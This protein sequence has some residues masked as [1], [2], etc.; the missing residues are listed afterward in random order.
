MNKNLE[1][2]VVYTI[3]TTPHGEAR[4]AWRFVLIWRCVAAQ[5]C[6][7]NEDMEEEGATHQVR[8]FVWSLS[9]VDRL[10]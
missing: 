3:S 2:L 8:L 9:E 6:A 1:A 7:R 10:R 4:L 5:A